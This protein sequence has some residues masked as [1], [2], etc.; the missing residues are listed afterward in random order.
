MKKT[1]AAAL[2][3]GAAFGLTAATVA[4]VL[5]R[6]E[7]REAAKRLLDKSA[8]MAQQVRGLSERAA[9]SAVAQYQAQAPRAVSALSGVLAQAPQ[10]AEAISA[11]LP[12]IGATGKQEPVTVTA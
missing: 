2:I 5:S 10:V 12:K 1:Q 8:P 11:K 9:K 6:S 7:G 4:V 3:A